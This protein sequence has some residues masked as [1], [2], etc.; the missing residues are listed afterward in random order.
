M[1]RDWELQALCRREDPDI[2]FSRSTVAAAKAV[3]GSCPVRGTCLEATLRREEGLAKTD[4]C[5]IA[6]GLTGAQR[7]A[8]AKARGEKS[9]LP[10]GSRGPGRPLAP[11]GTRS[12]YQRHI[13]RSEPVDAACQAANAAASKDYLVTGTTAG[14]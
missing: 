3:C 12:A 14:R 13:K 1:D 4:R 10:E 9:K 5:G 11:C 2:F 7:A 8:I 6:A